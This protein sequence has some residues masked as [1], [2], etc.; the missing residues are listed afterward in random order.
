MAADPQELK[1]QIAQTREG[2]GGNLDL[3]AEKVTPSK[4]VGRRVDA[5]KG[6]I[7][8]LRDHVMEVPTTPRAR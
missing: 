7:G 8:G 2:L 6:S 3:L 5:V 1:A 4:I